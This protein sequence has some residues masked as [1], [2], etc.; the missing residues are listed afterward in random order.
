MINQFINTL[1]CH[2]LV[3]PTGYQN[4]WNIC[5]EG[6]DGPN[7]EMV[8]ELVTTLQSYTNINPTRIRI[9]GFS[10]GASLA[11]RVFI[12]NNNAG[13]D[14]VCAVV[15]QMTE[16]LYRSGNFYKPSVTTTTASS[17]FCDYNTIVNPLKTR[18]YLSISNTNDNLIPYNGG[19]FAG[20]RFLPAETAAFNI[21]AYKGYTGSILTS[22]TVMG[23]GTT[24]ITEYSYLSGDVVH[25]KRNAM[26]STNISQR[27]YIKDY[28]SDCKT[29][30]GTENLE[31]FKT[32]I[33]PNPSSNSFN[34]W[35]NTTLLSTDYSVYDMLGRTVLYGKI[36]S[37]NISVDIST[38]SKGI[39]LL[40]FLGGEFKKS[41][42]SN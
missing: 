26:H 28:F 41:V 12:E 16:A 4:S 9:L 27:N 23:S 10:N 22:G 8:N 19:L 35:V 13:I 40:S 5:T 1:Q 29:V 20:L 24:T 17:A 25:I 18:N 7:V 33:Y 3:A 38:L 21:A 37:E 6:S 32:E 36:N 34:L 11:N 42:E 30:L 31:I 15:S 2:I 39:Y 14:I